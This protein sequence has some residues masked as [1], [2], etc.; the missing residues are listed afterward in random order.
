YTQSHRELVHIQESMN[1]EV[2]EVLKRIQEH[3]LER[4]NKIA[5]SL[6]EF[7]RTLSNTA[8]AYLECMQRIV[9][10]IDKVDGSTD[11]ECFVM[12]HEKLLEEPLIPTLELHSC[13]SRS[14][15]K[16]KTEKSSDDFK[17]EDADDK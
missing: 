16:A 17:N 6:K 15:R 12:E 3:E 9:F 11:I 1:S 10:S 5:R 8:P 4:V 14:N 7:A 13:S 2:N